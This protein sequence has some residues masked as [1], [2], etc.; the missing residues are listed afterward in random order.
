MKQ[1][2]AIP[3]AGITAGWLLQ[4]PKPINQNLFL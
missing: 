4:K 1:A 3:V 2:A